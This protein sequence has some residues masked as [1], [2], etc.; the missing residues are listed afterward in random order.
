MKFR[1]QIRI[2]NQSHNETFTTKT[3][4]DILINAENFDLKPGKRP[5]GFQTKKIIFKVLG[6]FRSHTF[7]T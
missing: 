4:I 7:F 3:Q 1:I 2:Y 5:E 6:Q